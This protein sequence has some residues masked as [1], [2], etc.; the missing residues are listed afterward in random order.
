MEAVIGNGVT[1]TQQFRNTAGTLTDPSTVTLVVREPDGT[2][3]TY[4]YG[5][6]VEVVRASA[7]VFTFSHTPDQVGRYGY[8]WVGT[9]TVAYAEEQFITITASQVLA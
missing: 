9:G 6:D 4:I 1:T 2:R 5:T 8:R 7:G 3:V